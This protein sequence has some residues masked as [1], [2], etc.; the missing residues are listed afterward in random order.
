M[1]KEINNYLNFI[2]PC[3][4]LVMAAKNTKDPKEF[5]VIE[6]ELINKAVE[7]ESPYVLLDFATRVK[8]AH[9]NKFIDALELIA[10]KFDGKDGSKR[11]LIAKAA[12][13][14]ASKFK[15]VDTQKLQQ[16]VMDMGRPQAMLIFANCVDDV[17]LEKLKSAKKAS[18]KSFS[19]S[20]KFVYSS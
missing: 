10:K 2:R 8:G 6:Q 3:K 5:D 11:T 17:D 16:I 9:I 13:E 12:C 7:H 4:D 15:N 20:F 19:L 14:F 18:N 1:E